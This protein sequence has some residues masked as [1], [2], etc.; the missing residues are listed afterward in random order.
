MIASLMQNRSRLI[1]AD[2]RA[3]LV[4]VIASTAIIVGSSRTP[5]ANA[6]QENIYWPGREWRTASPETQGLD[7]AVL[8]D[9]FD[10]IREHRTRIHSLTI[11]RNGYVVLDTTFFPFQPDLLHDVASVTKSITATLIGVAIENRQLANVNQPL[12]S[13]FPDRVIKNRDD[14]KERLT[15]EH[16]LIMSSGLDCQVQRRRAHVASDAGQP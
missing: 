9:A 8:A 1:W 5:S 7:S 15:L 3:V 14:R 10:Y 2:P 16:L 13:L 11:V 12:V 4:M 6:N